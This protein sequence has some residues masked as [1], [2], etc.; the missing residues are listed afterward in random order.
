VVLPEL[1]KKR[2]DDVKNFH[3]ALVTGRRD[4]L[5]SET[6]Q[7]ERSL[8][9]RKQQLAGLD[10]QARRLP[11]YHSSERFLLEGIFSREPWDS[12]RGCR[13]R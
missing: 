2:L 3:R 5:S 13:F 4:F 7:L 6:V 1:V 10:G 9:A 12:S 8:V 11:Y